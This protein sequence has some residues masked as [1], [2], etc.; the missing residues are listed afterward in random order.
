MIRKTPRLSAE[1]Y[2]TIEDLVRLGNIAVAEAQEESRRLG[3]A[4]VYSINGR[5]YCE[6]PSGELSLEDPDATDQ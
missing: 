4:N 6:I 5:I 1:T 2:A 3:V